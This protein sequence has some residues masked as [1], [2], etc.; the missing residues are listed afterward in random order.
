[1]TSAKRTLIFKFIK[2][3][4]FIPNLIPIP[5]PVSISLLLKYTFV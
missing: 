2:N 4:R 5:I 1:M 3:S